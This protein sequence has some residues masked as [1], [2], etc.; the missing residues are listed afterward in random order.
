MDEVDWAILEMLKNNARISN[1]SIGRSLNI[2]EGTV[3]KRIKSLVDQG[4]IKKFTIVMKNEGVE[5]IVVLRLDPKR[6][7]N[8]ISELENRFEEIFE[9]S[10]RFDVAVKVMAKDLD[11]LNSTV[12]SLREIE[13]VKGSDT[14]IRL[15]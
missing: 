14:L 9:F 5:A 11:A 1:S 6:A 3:R 7:K 8:V 4:I 12:D 2:S 15:H 13:G 10:G